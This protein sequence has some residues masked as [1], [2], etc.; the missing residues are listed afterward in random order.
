MTDNSRTPE[1]ERPRQRLDDLRLPRSDANQEQEPAGPRARPAPGTRPEFVITEPARERS[2]NPAAEYLPPKPQKPRLAVFG[3]SFNPVHNG[4]LFLAGHLLRAGLADEILF[5]PAGLPPHKSTLDLAPA[6]LRYGMLRLALAPFPEFSVS[7]IEIQQK[8]R[9]SYTIETL[10][11]LRVAFP[12]RLLLFLMGTDS[13]AELHTWHRATE[14][15][16]QFN[17]I[18]YP[19]PEADAPM[20]VTLA[21]RFGSRNAQKLRAAI[22]EAPLLP[23]T[24]SAIRACYGE[25][26]SVAGMLPE[27]V[28]AFIVQNRLYNAKPDG[29]AHGREHETASAGTA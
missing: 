7:D 14:L 29:N 19:R 22:I 28:H 24:A 21:G 8:E 25:G 5:I 27:A 26:T 6:D 4:H 17:F 23:V 18:I 12:E 16:N 10:D 13:L 2:Y 9:P 15:V 11:T 1:R 20:T 3:G